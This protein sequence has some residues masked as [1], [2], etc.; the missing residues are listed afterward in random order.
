M[1]STKIALTMLLQKQVITSKEYEM[2]LERGL[3]LDEDE[4]SKDNVG[5]AAEISS[6]CLCCEKGLSTEGPK[7]CPVCDHEFQGNGWDG[8]DAHWRAKHAG[9]MSYEQFWESLCDAHRG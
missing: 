5:D 8:I 2:I 6:E 1:R 7:I 3:V 9:V 4:Q